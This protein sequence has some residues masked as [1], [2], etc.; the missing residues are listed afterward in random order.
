MLPMRVLIAD[1]HRL[2]RQGLISLMNTRP[3]LVQV[4]GEAETGREAVRLTA[5]LQPDLVLMD[6]YMPHSDGLSAT[7]VIR[8]RF[9]DVDVVILTASDLDEHFHTA[10]QSGVAGY[11]LKDLDAKEL[12]NLIEGIERGE[13]ALTR[14]MATRLLKDVSNRAIESSKGEEILTSREIEVLRLLAQGA[15]NAQ[16]G[17]ELNITVNTVK[18]HISHIL[19]KLNLENRTQAATY[20]IQSRIVSQ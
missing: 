8:D 15:S 5:E 9:P 10:I 16:I 1:D 4:V 13:A 18:T 7:Q 2:F 17:Q 12:F 11:L 6:I 14:A 19:D 3:D 20:A